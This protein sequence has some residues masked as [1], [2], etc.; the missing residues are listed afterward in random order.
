M[1][2]RYTIRTGAD[3]KEEYSVQQGSEIT[4]F[5]A[6]LTFDFDVLWISS[7]WMRSTVQSRLISQD[8]RTTDMTCRFPC[9]ILNRDARTPYAASRSVVYF[10]V[11]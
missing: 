11:A 10:S 1:P 8:I 3:G 6:S 9:T 2:P 4:I 7:R 5:A